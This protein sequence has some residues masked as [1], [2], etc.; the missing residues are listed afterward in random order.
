MLPQMAHNLPTPRSSLIGR[1]RDVSEVTR[2]VLEGTERLVTLTGVGGCG[3]TRLALQVAAD[4][5]PVFADGVWL[6]ELA[7]VLDPLLVP[8]VVASALGVHERAVQ[9]SSLT[10]ALVASLRERALL[11]VLDNCEHLID[12]CAS[13]VDQLLSG[14]PNLRILATSREPIHV[15]GERQRH[16][17]PLPVPDPEHVA[18]PGDLARC[19]AVQLFVERASAVEANFRLTPENAASLARIC[20]LLDG[21]PLA[22]ELA[23]PRVRVLSVGQIA[24]RLDDGLRLLSGNSR[25]APTRQQTLKAT[26]DWSYNLL[27]GPEQA[28]FRRLAVFSGGWSLEAAEAVCHGDGL[29]ETEVL[30]LLT[31]LVDKSLVLVW[32]QAEESRYRFLEPVRQYAAHLLVEKQEDDPTWRRLASFCIDLAERAEP[33]FH[34]PLQVTWLRR[35]DREFDNVRVVIRWAET[36][37]DTGT[38]LRL[39]GTLH[40]FFWMHQHL[41]EGQRWL[42][43]SLA[44]D[45]A[46]PPKVRAKALFAAALVCSFLNETTRGSEFGREARALFRELG[47]ADGVAW[48]ATTLAHIF[49]AQGDLPRAFSMAEEGVAFARASGASGQLGHALT[50][51]GQVVRMQ[52]DERRSMALHQEAREVFQRCGDRWGLEF[53]SAILH[54]TALGHDKFDIQRLAAMSSVRLYHERD[55]RLAMAGALEYLAGRDETGRGETRVRLLAAADTLRRSLGAQVPIGE[56]DDFERHLTAARTEL[57]A[58]RFQAIWNEYGAMPLEQIV[59]NVLRMELPSSRSEL[60]APSG[61]PS[62]SSTPR[63]RA[64]GPSDILTRR[65]REVAKL[66]AAGYTD[67]QIAEELTITEGT[68]GVHVHHILEKLRLRSRVQVVDW[69]LAQG[70]ID[71]RPE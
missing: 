1:E 50:I 13:L 39:A 17:H 56:R 9:A 34:G 33:Q 67:R 10:G 18:S 7:P 58:A 22:L 68:T 57:G 12:A 63:K 30:E 21:I 5:S 32:E 49:F 53:V 69:A 41:R 54:L 45:A 59:A 71:A 37:G 42:E 36:S 40:W 47:D 23:A 6:V 52:G 29:P 51:L 11:L 38:A 62:R 48:S 43:A 65:E 27:S 61:A 19:P 14:C 44:K 64:P 4:L 2:L 46:V 28:A 66:L 60:T 35:L 31:Q 25:S 55:D 20:T 8:Q 70:L 16:V 24:Q 15:T 26:L 3:K